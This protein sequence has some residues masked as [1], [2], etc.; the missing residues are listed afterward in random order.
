MSSGKVAAEQEAVD[1]CQ[2]LQI[3]CKKDQEALR[4]HAL[5]DPGTPS[6]R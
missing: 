1:G 6:Q 4:R 2:K 5:R 3:E